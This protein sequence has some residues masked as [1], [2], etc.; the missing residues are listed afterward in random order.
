VLGGGWKNPERSYLVRLRLLNVHQPTREQRQDPKLPAETYVAM[1]RYGNTVATSTTISGAMRH[2]DTMMRT[3][4]VT[5]RGEYT[6]D[7]QH[8]GFGK[9]RLIATRE[10][11]KWLRY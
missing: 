1:D 9:G 10:N 3:G 2:A 5:V 11:G 7:G 6:S 8:W 4:Y